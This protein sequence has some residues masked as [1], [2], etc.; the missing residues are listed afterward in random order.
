MC[1]YNAA[2]EDA[3]DYEAK[4][5]ELLSGSPSTTHK[6]CN[7]KPF[8]SLALLGIVERITRGPPACYGAAHDVDA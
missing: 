3:Q 8:S 5:S 7:A 1:S 2:V 6:G 4:V